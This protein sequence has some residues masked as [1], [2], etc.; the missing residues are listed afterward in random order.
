MTTKW[1]VIGLSESLREELAPHRIGVTA[2]CPGVIRTP[3]AQRWAQV[4]PEIPARMT[5]M[6]PIGRIGEPE[7]IAAAVLW[8]CSDAASFVTGIAQAVDGGF[9]AI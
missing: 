6:H 2:V 5:A 9:T 7:E 1:A 4:D 8:L 3:M